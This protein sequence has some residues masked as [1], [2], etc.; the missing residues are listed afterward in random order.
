MLRYSGLVVE[1]S[2]IEE[3]FGFGSY[4]ILLIP[5]GIALHAIGGAALI[6]IITITCGGECRRI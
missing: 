2:C 4:G 3:T 1:P 5:P 6:D